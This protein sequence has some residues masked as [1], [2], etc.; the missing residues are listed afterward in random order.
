MR[1]LSTMAAIL[2][3]CFQVSLKMFKISAS[4]VGTMAMWKWVCAFAYKFLTMVTEGVVHG[5]HK[6][7]I[8][9]SFG[10]IR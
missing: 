3:F 9:S 5:V 10:V 7:V 8:Q 1:L 6:V 4:E 2:K